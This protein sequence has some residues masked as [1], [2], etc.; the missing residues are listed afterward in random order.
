MTSTRTSSSARRPLSLGRRA[1]IALTVGAG[2][3]LTPL[4]ALAAP[5]ATPVAAQSAT[6]AASTASAQG[7]VN[8]ALAQLGKPY[9]YGGA[10]PHAFDCSGLTQFAYGAVGIGLPHSARAQSG[11]GIPV[12]RANLQP[13]DLVFFYGLGHVG[14]YVGNNQVVHAPTSGSVV[15]VTDIGYMPFSGARRLA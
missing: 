10:G 4:P 3:A 14:I 11:H 15:K 12:A 5:A 8:T 6:V 7:A 13:G 2:V 9:V 1:A